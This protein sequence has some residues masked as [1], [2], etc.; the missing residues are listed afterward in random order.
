[1]DK[2]EVEREFLKSYGIDKNT[3]SFEVPLEDEKK[4]RAYHDYSWQESIWRRCQERPIH[5]FTSLA[6]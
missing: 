4:L 2:R 6:T 3:E 1:M 5:F